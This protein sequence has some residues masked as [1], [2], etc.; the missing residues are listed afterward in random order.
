M[1]LRH[2]AVH[3]G[4]AIAARFEFFGQFGGRRFGADEYQD[5]VEGL[6]FEDARQRVE[7]VKAADLPVA[8]PDRVGRRGFRRDRDFPRLA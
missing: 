6:D 8:L 4:C 5:G 1:C 7:L 3:R 2:V